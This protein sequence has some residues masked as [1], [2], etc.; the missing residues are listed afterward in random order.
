MNSADPGGAIAFVGVWVQVGGT[1]LLLTL[2]Y[3]L[4]RH[5][6]ARPYFVRWAWAWLALFGAIVAVVLRYR[7]A[8]AFLPHGAP[9]PASMV[10]PL[11]AAYLFGKLVHL[12]LLVAGTWQLCRVEPVPGKPVAW[13]LGAG[14]L[15]LV[16]AYG[17]T[18]LNPIMPIQAIVA[19]AAFTTC[20]AWL[21]HL[22]P[23]HRTRGTQFTATVFAGLALLWVIYGVLFARTL[24]WPEAEP[25]LLGL[26][27][28]LNSFLDT[29]ASMLL[30]IGMVVILLEDARREA[31]RAR[32]EHLRSVAESEARLAEALR[33]EALGRLVSG[34]AH[35]LNNP[36]AAIL[37]FS[38]QLLE[39]RPDEEL[40]APLATIRDQARRARAVVRDLLTFVRRREERREWADV[41]VLVQR[42]T[43]A[44]AADFQRQGVS[45][46]VVL[47]PGLP[48]LA[49]DPPA[50]EQVLTNLLDNATRAAPGGA[51]SLR[52]RREQ[53]NL[54][55]E[56]EDSGPGI[57]PQ[58][59]VR[60][61]EPFF[62]TRGTGEGTG[63]GLSV[64]LGIAQQHGGWLRAENREP[65]P[66]ARLVA[67][68][69]LGHVPAGITPAPGSAPIPAEKPG[70]VGQALIIDDEAPVRASIRR[71][72]ERT[73]WQVTEATN[74]REGL[75]LLLDKAAPDYG[76]VLCDLKMPGL[77]GRDVY[78]QVKVARPALLSRLVF[79]SGDTASPDTAEF[80]AATPCAVLEKPFELS[81]L[82]AVVGR[83]SGPGAGAD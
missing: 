23:E 57:P 69:P 46:T 76:I 43:R 33:M 42:T 72:L 68:F 7:M 81:E 13:L 36:L 6:G 75:D 70:P 62:T 39:E 80:L 24:L 49:C 14:L 82:A 53:N 29:G 77:S 74:G 51:V 22:T 83:V 27:P 40:A 50:I 54:R 55:I 34:V 37:T 26:F 38:E 64:S 59:L 61:F 79:A 3:L 60:I 16:T 44:L 48:P 65:G 28:R 25:G 31:D 21:F 67:S 11:H 2:F 41:G 63:L 1:V 52:V 12:G 78:Q 66:G 5:A 45:L 56:V 73:G 30:A 35:E 9:A 10:A 17:T 8:P 47:E 71:Y 20:A 18:D 4:G 58:H 15:T 32:V 19:V